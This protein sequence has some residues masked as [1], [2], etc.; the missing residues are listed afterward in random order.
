[1]KRSGHGSYF[2]VT[3]AGCLLPLLIIFNLFF[4]RVFLKTPV[5]LGAE[6]FLILLLLVNS[7]FLARRVSGMSARMR[8][9]I[10]V[11]G[12]IVEE[13]QKNRIGGN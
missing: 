6:I 7:H 3:Q 12:E 9:V 11:E 4:G 10:D 1:M 13:T 5:W 2:L 8:D